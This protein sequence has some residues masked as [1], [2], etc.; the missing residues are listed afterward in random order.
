MEHD[1]ENKFRARIPDDDMSGWI[2][3]L[4]KKGFADEEMDYILAYLNKTYAKAKGIDLVEE[5]LK[6]L[7]EYLREMHGRVLT[8]EQK[9]YLTKAIASRSE[10]Q[11]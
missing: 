4:R 8:E 7:E 9:E 3:A 11:G 1:T 2:Q 5:E 6:R 10:F